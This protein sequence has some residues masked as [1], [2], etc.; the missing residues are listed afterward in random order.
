MLRIGKTHGIRLSTMP[1]SKPKTM[2]CSMSAKAKVVATGTV[3]VVAVVRG[4]SGSLALGSDSSTPEALP[5][6]ASASRPRKTAETPDA[7][8]APPPA[9]MTKRKVPPV[10][11][12]RCSS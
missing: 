10:R 4:G 8:S 2:A 3:G 7:C 11:S 6:S 12:T 5:M 1:P 9:G